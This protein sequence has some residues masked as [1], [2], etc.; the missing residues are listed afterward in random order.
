MRVIELFENISRRNFISGL[1]SSHLLSNLF[2]KKVSAEKDPKI[3]NLKI[4]Y[5]KNYLMKILDEL[6]DEYMNLYKIDIKEKL[7]NIELPKIKPVYLADEKTTMKLFGIPIDTQ[8]YFINFYDHIN[9]IIYLSPDAEP[10]NLVHELVHFI[11]YKITH[12]G[13]NFDDYMEQEAVKFQRLKNW[14]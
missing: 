13:E 10:H 8:K 14:K 11:Q 3:K 7:K 2:I 9:N 12:V 5:D 4:F 1:L 6:A